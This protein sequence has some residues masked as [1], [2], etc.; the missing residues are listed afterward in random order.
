MQVDVPWLIFHS[1]PVN[2]HA[3]LRG[4]LQPSQLPNALRHELEDFTDRTPNYGDGR[5]HW[6]PYPGG[7]PLGEWYVVSWTR[8]DD[9]A[10]RRGSI[11]T[12]ALLFPREQLAASPD[13]P[14]AIRAAKGE[15]P[16]QGH[17]LVTLT[18]NASPVT[19]RG[20][21]LLTL[22]AQFP[23]QPVALIGE[24]HWE[25][26]ITD[27]WAALWP[28]ARAHF[29]FRAFDAPHQLVGNP[30]LLLV[31]APGHAWTPPAWPGG[32]L[33]SIPETSTPLAL[34]H[35]Q[36]NRPDIQL[37]GTV[38]QA[39]QVNALAAA[40]LTA[41]DSTE[42]TLRALI[43]LQ[44]SPLTESIQTKLTQEFSQQ[45]RGQ[46]IG[47]PG[48][49]IAQ[50]SALPDTSTAALQDPVT[51]WFEHALVH[52]PPEAR[53]VA[54]TTNLPTW[55]EVALQSA[56]RSIPPGEGVAQLLWSWWTESVL[57]SRTLP[58]LAPG[59]DEVLVQAIPVD[60]M[61]RI[62]RD[63]VLARGWPRLYGLLTAH[64]EKWHDLLVLPENLRGIALS[65]ARQSVSP[66]TFLPWA[67][68]QSDPD[69]LEQAAQA[70]IAQPTL[71]ADADL[72]QPHWL[73]VWT[74]ALPALMPPDPAQRFTD[75]LE[76]VDQG[77]RVPEALL[78]ALASEGRGQLLHHPRR[79]LL[80]P[81]L[82]QTYWNQTADAFLQSAS[83]PGP[84]GEALLNVITQRATTVHPSNA[85][86]RRIMT[87]ISPDHLPQ[88]VERQVAQGLTEHD[89][90]YIE[91]LPQGVL[92]R[93]LRWAPDTL[94]WHYRRHLKPV[95]TVVLA[96]RLN[97]TVEV[98]AW[99]QAFEDFVLTLGIDPQSV[100]S[101][102]DWSI[103]DFPK[104][105]S[106]RD[107]WQHAI[108]EMQTGGEATT[109][110][111]LKSLQHRRPQ[112]T[113]EFSAF[114]AT[115]PFKRH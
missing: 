53:Q 103:V 48:R 91:S 20:R 39:R 49:V 74:N 107:A 23:E 32:V 19:Q 84:V 99:R 14:S 24:E 100:W 109:R 34:E 92:S 22:F 51:E 29:T 9:N 72:H 63:Q 76:L 67:I 1:H 111:V 95:E 35:L 26:G 79:D 25:A 36:Q 7:R 13:L 28:S 55:M 69:V 86:S 54:S 59:W 47:I 8:R 17:F 80:L 27:L 101:E 87:E 96:H 110:E 43:Q 5:E 98:R 85:A 56:L 78:I 6:T 112:R 106:Q 16:A 65:T 50:L 93:L 113:Q 73:S 30:D 102:R 41:P 38:R 4:S 12:Q 33:R 57:L 82:P 40:L 15:L 77:T 81:K 88:L 21:A 3:F 66:A 31:P 71:L 108:Q 10:Q 90:D 42:N 75:V 58:A 64:V 60:G 62:H 89:V 61:A 52:Q 94:R 83:D 18:D 104:G 44:H 45:V 11:I 2:G 114:Q 70:L 46:L 68:Q 97:R 115:S 37:S 105:A